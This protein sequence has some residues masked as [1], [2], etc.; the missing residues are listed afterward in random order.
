M[1]DPMSLQRLNLSQ[2]TNFMLIAY[3]MAYRWIEWFLD[4]NFSRQA[5]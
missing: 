3:P 2:F 4:K 1:A 5:Q